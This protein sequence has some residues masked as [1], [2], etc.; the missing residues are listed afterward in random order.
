MF[1]MVV[2]SFGD[3]GAASNRREESG[4]SAMRLGSQ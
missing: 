4:E 1:F 3:D 2:L